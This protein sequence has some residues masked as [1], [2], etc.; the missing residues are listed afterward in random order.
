MK[1][2]TLVLA[3]IMFFTVFVWASDDAAAL[4]ATAASHMKI[5]AQEAD[6]EET[7][8]EYSKSGKKEKE[9]EV[10]KQKAQKGGK[11][12]TGREMQPACIFSP[13]LF[14][15]DYGFNILQKDSRIKMG[16]EEIIAVKTGQEAKYPQARILINAGFI[17]RVSMY[18]PTGQ[19]Y[20]EVTAQRQGNTVRVTERVIS[21]N[22]TVVREYL[23][24]KLKAK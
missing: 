3:V 19:K 13:E 23:Y 8:A 20:Y 5:M 16:R 7:L 14:F 1:K 2:T 22:N 6:Y 11:A 10:R 12:E 18:G 9:R 21:L 17:E 24:R 4:I 15:K